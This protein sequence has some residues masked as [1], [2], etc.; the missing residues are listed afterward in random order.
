M[1][2]EKETLPKVEENVL[3]NETIKTENLFKVLSETPFDF[4]FE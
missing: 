4:Y 2:I 3:Q 1:P